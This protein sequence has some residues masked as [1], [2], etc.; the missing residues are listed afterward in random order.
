MSPNGL[1]LSAQVT[2]P[3]GSVDNNGHLIADAGSIAAQAQYVNQNGLVQANS[4][5]NVNGTIELVASDSVNLGAHSAIT[6]KGDSSSVSAGGSVTIQSANNF[7]DQ[8]GSLIDVSGSAQGG[9]GGQVAISAPQ[10][11]LLQSTINGQAISGYANAALSINTA[12]IT[13][14]GD[15]SPVTGQLALNVNALSPGISQL[16]L[17]ASGSIEVSS[18]LSLTPQSGVLN[19]VS[20]IA[21]GTLTVDAGAGIGVNGGKIYLSANTVS[22][23]GMLQANYDLNAN[24]VIEIDAN[25]SL[26]LGATSQID[27][28]GESTAISPG[29]IVV[30]KSGN[31]YADT[32]TSQ[33]NVSG[34]EGGRT[35]SLKFLGITWMALWAILWMPTRFNPA[36]AIV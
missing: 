24:G 13:L 12:D 30:L 14:N 29:G 36:L 32:P 16:D 1:G 17:Q 9:A 8:A 19:M 21:G 35:G 10:M 7:S 4:V 26:T 5:Q 31:T 11:S 15:G 34:S 25:N 22:Q 3:Q 33:I 18:L 28:N 23:N 20:L 27:A 2:L 6:A